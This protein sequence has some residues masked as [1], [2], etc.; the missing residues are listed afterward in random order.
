M[1]EIDALSKDKDWKMKCDTQSE[2]IKPSSFLEDYLL[3]ILIPRLH[4]RITQGHVPGP[5]QESVIQLSEAELSATQSASLKH[6]R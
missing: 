5:S 4:V 6:V 1:E 3:G 2:L